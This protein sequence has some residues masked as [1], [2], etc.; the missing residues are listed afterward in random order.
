MDKKN[1]DIII[2]LGRPAA[3]KSEVIDY[4]KKTPLAERQERFHI[5]KFE[6]IDDFPMLWTWFEEDAILEKILKKPRLYTDQK[7]YFLYEYFWH[8]LIERISLDYSKKMRDHPDYHSEFTSIIEFSRGSQHGGYKAAFPHL[9]DEIL[10]KAGIVYID[11]S[12]QESLRKNRRRFNPNR[13]DSI[14]EHG[15]PDHKLERL[16][17]EIDWEEVS[18]SDPNFI[19]IKSYKVPYVVFK[20]EPEITDQP[21]KLGNE[22]E[23]ILQRLWDLQTSMA[24]SKK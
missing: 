19:P 7:G 3:G 9:S 2:L 6:E 4:L 22:L 24:H 17:K 11:V 15:L 14:L 23:K 18:A 5:G 1:F 21:Q 8:L 20:N 10:K 16:Y 12:Y 13:P